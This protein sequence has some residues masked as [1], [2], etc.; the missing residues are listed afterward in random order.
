M[1][2]QHNSN[3]PQ[4]NKGNQWKDFNAQEEVKKVNENLKELRK[5]HTKIK[6]E[7]SLEDLTPQPK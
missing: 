5:K 7:T 4:R 6:R 1:K 3:L 2:A